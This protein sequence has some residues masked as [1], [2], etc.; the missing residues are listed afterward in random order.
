LRALERAPR[1]RE[2]RR[3]FIELLGIVVFGVVADQG[4][5]HVLV[6]T[7]PSIRYCEMITKR[8]REAVLVEQAI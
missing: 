4:N 6:L 8:D 7:Q 5:Q 1:L 2:L 3:Q